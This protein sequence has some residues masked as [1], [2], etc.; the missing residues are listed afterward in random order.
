LNC[1]ALKRA[2]NPRVLIATLQRL[3]HPKSE[4]RNQRSE[5]AVL[6]EIP[7]PAEVRRIFGMTMV[8][9]FCRQRRKHLLALKSEIE[10]L[11]SEIAVLYEIPRPAE[12]RRIFGMTN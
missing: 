10:N 8:K 5:N 6:Y 4:I 9:L 11:R 7:R 1:Q 3:R 2:L 12:V